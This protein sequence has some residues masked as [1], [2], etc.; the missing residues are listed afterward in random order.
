[1]I[2]YG[3]T[4]RRWLLIRL[5]AVCL[6]SRGVVSFLFYRVVPLAYSAGVGTL[7]SKGIA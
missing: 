5:G 1:M 2:C 4:R 6:A 7:L 3:D